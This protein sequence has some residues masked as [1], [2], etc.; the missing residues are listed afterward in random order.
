MTIFVNG[1]WLTTLCEMTITK[2]ET[3]WGRV[4]KR[5]WVAALLFPS[6]VQSSLLPRYHHVEHLLT[7]FSWT[8]LSGAE[9]IRR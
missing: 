9:N 2:V 4:F 6:L 5:V 7:P 1:P 8:L 3:E